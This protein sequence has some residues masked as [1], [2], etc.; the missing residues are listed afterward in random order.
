MQQR[1]LQPFQNRAVEFD[2]ASFDDQFDFL[3]GC[4]G[5]VVDRAIQSQTR[6]GK[7]QHADAPDFG[8][9]RTGCVIE[10]PSVG[11][12]IGRQAFQIT[13]QLPDAVARVRERLCG[14]SRQSF[15]TRA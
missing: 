4:A 1:I 9:E 10:L 6:L 14:T 11:H 12:G 13:F 3:A 8:V 15:N 2:F 5:E 7:R